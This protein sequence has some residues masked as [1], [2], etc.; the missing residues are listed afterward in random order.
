[1]ALAE[2]SHHNVISVRRVRRVEEN[3]IE[4]F[5]VLA[6]TF[7]RGGH[8]AIDYS[9]IATCAKR[10]QVSFDRR[11]SSTGAFDERHA[12]CAAAERFDANR[13]RAR[14][15]IKEMAVLNSRREDIEQRLSQA[16]GCR[17]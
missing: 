4:R 15:E 14:A 12:F 7:E 2:L 5:E 9:C 11:A 13:S 17:S 6:E 10:I 1:M 16:V 3:H 8:L